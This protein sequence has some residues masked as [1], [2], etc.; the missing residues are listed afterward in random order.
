MKNER[1]RA[2]LAQFTLELTRDRLYDHQGQQVP[3]LVDGTRVRISAALPIRQWTRALNQTVTKLKQ[4]YRAM[5]RESLPKRQRDH[6]AP[7]FEEAVRKVMGDE[8]VAP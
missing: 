7:D 6:F 3:V 2:Y 5:R 4:D 1:L 8:G